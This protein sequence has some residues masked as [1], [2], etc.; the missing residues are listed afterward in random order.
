MNGYDDELWSPWI[1]EAD[2]EDASKF[3]LTTAGDS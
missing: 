1:N 2:Q 3:E